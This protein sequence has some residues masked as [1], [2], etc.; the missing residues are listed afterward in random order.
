MHLVEKFTLGGTEFSW[1]YGE[2]VAILFS[3][4]RMELVEQVNITLKENIVAKNQVMYDFNRDVRYYV[5]R[6]GE[7]YEVDKLKSVLKLFPGREKM[8]KRYANEN[9]LDFKLYRQSAL[10]TIMKYADELLAQ[11]LK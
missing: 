9:A 11:P 1:R 7:V 5:L 10:I 2:I 8:L 3:S 4:P 6:G